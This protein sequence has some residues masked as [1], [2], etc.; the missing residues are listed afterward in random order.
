VPRSRPLLALGGP[1]VFASAVAVLAGRQLVRD[2]P[3]GFDWPTYF[4]D[5]RGAAWAAVLVL[6]I[7]VIVDRAWS[8]S[9]WPPERSTSLDSG[10]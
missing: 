2:L 5:T 6:A 1:L 7:D 4:T 9:W 10:R 8:G 3:A